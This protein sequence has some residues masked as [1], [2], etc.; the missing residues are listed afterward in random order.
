MKKTTAEQAESLQPWYQLFE[1]VLTVKQSS[2]NL[3]RYFSKDQKDQPKNDW[4]ILISSL[5]KCFV[6]I[7]LKSFLFHCGVLFHIVTYHNEMLFPKATFHDNG[8]SALSL[9][10]CASLKPASTI[11]ATKCLLEQRLCQFIRFI[12]T[13]EII[14]CLLCSWL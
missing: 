2:W 7:F 6:S 11:A 13:G 10:P 5:Y 4:P 1:A 14:L 9:S 12:I 8:V 3:L